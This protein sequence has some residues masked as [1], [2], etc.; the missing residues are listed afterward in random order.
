[1][2]SRQSQLA[3]LG[4]WVVVVMISCTA[5]IVEITIIGRE[6]LA[7]LDHAVD[8]S[9]RLA[10]GN[11]P[12]RRLSLLK[13]VLRLGAARLDHQLA[14]REVAGKGTVVAVRLVFQGKKI[15][16]LGNS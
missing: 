14:Q 2:Q 16:V 15:G 9:E 4:D 7:L 11:H 13:G 6:R 3:A 8:Q 5:D 1:M 12:G 10:A